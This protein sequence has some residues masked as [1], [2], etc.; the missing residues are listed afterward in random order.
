MSQKIPKLHVTS[1]PQG[2]ALTLSSQT[3]H[4]VDSPFMFSPA[5]MPLFGFSFRPL[6]DLAQRVFLSELNRRVASPYLFRSTWTAVEQVRITD[7]H[8]TVCVCVG[9]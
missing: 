5:A 9:G 7:I 3:F 4:V 8:G 6:V 1:V 2:L